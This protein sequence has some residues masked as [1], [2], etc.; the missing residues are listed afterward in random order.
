MNSIHKHGRRTGGAGWS[1]PIPEKMLKK[2]YMTNYKKKKH[3]HGQVSQI[4]KTSAI[5]IKFLYL[6]K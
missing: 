6:H 1:V 2:I 4:I 3:L 5:F